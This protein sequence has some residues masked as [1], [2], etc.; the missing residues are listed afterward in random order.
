MT[1][2]E[3][4]AVTLSVADMGRSY[5][6]YTL[7]GFET[8]YGGPD[9]AF[10]SLRIVGQFLNLDLTPGFHLA[11]VWG[12]VIFHVDSVDAVYRRALEAGF[13]PETEPRDAEWGERYFH[14]LDPDGH[15][16]S[17]AKLL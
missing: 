12:R 2:R 3:I 16:L 6:F 1:L 14:I 8:E 17:F 5:R 4:N 7:L 13:K 15:E 10:T 9:A 11:G